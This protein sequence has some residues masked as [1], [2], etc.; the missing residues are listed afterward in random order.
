MTRRVLATSI[1]ATLAL[2]VVGVATALAGHGYD[3]GSP[4]RRDTGGAVDDGGG[5]IGLVPILI[6]VGL[7]LVAAAILI[8]QNPSAVRARL[9]T[10]VPILIIS[11]L[12]ATPLVVWTASSGGDPKPLIVERGTASTGKPELLVSLTGKGMNTLRATGGRRS[13]RIRCVG[14]DGRMVVDGRQRWPFVLERGYDYPHAHHLATR[15]QVQRV[16]RC[17]LDGTR[18]RLEADVEGSLSG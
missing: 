1:A 14:R 5:G 16:D 4:Q 18:T 17:R 11:A 6:V 7:V 3:T 8:A 12:I 9:P 10:A 13:V 2:L 15:E